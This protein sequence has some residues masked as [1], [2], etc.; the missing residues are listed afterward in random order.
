MGKKRGNNKSCGLSSLG[1]DC[2]LKVG[3]I[4]FVESLTDGDVEVVLMLLPQITLMF[5]L[6]SA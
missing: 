6:N 5:P 4:F 1:G 3:W 2:L